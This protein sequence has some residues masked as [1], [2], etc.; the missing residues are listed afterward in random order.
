MGFFTQNMINR[1]FKET[2]KR[3]LTVIDRYGLVKNKMFDNLSIFIDILEEYDA[4][5]TIPVTARV[6]QQNPDFLEILNNKRVEIAVH[7]YKHIDHTRL[8]N[9]EIISHLNKAMEVF[10]ENKIEVYGFRAPYL[11]VN[12]N[13]IKAINDVGL[14]YDSS[15][16]VYFEVLPDNLENYENV[17]RLIKSYDPRYNKPGVFKMGEISEIPVSFPDDEILVDRLN[18]NSRKV[19]ECWIKILEET[20]RS[21]ESIFVLQLHPE[22]INLLK[23]ALTELIEFAINRNVILTNLR[24]IVETGTRRYNSYLAISGDIDILTLPDIVRM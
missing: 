16:P 12:D 5:A 11:K 10:K 15:Y 24:E 18:F 22:R 4:K 2:V 14:K 19:A 6:L 21:D 23:G 3:G 13:V 7:G 9:E 1:G 20:M 17:R 8:S